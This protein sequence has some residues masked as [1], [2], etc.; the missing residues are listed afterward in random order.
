VR[1]SGLTQ[2]HRDIGI[3]SA[4]SQAP[5]IHGFCYS[6]GYF[7]QFAEDEDN[8]VML[9]LEKPATDRGARAVWRGSSVQLSL[10]LAAIAYASKVGF[11]DRVASL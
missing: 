10:R 3:I 4:S 7:V 8:V 9:F 6:V 2:G 5:K 1:P 11:R